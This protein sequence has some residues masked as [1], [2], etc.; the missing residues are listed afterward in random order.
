MHNI[1]LG[2]APTGGGQVAVSPLDAAL[3]S[4][5]LKQQTPLSLSE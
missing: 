5:W 2:G 1:E 3:L 4:A